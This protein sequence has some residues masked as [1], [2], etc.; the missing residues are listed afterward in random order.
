MLFDTL[1]ELCQ[2][3]IIQ[4][5]AS[6]NSYKGFR[7]RENSIIHGGWQYL[8]EIFLSRQCF[9]FERHFS[10]KTLFYS[11]ETKFASSL[12]SCS[13]YNFISQ[14]RCYNHQSLQIEVT[15][16]PSGIGWGCSSVDRVLVQQAGKPWFNS[17]HY[18]NQSCQ[19][20]EHRNWRQEDQLFKAI[21]SHTSS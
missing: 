17:Q 1:E 13:F 2:H 21:V 19:Y 5:Q 16:K 3:Q 15:T 12:P 18:V 4:P 7:Q 20:T 11:H 14:E 6:C 8:N 9:I 10:T